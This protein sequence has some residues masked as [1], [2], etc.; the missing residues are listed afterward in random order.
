VRFSISLLFFVL[1]ISHQG[2][3]SF[4]LL[5]WKMNQA[6]IVQK[7]CENRNKPEMACNGKCHLRKTLA[8]LDQSRDQRPTE[9]P[10]KAE[11][12]A[13]DYECPINNHWMNTQWDALTVTCFI[14]SN[15][16]ELPEGY[17]V[18]A[19]SP[20]SGTLRMINRIELILNHVSPSSNT[21]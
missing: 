3:R 2:L 1:L 15:E 13:M 11:W 9:S 8:K 7:H 19:E 17:S 4:V 5:Q 21:L 18:L 20:A 12:P 10:S 14:E 6:E 16:E